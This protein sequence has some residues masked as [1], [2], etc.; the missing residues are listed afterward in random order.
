MKKSPIFELDYYL[1]ADSMVSISS[2]R[3]LA[4]LRQAAL[5]TVER[6]GRA[7]SCLNA[8]HIR[9]RQRR[10]RAARPES[11]PGAVGAA[12]PATPLL[13]ALSDGRV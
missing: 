8:F 12:C 7:R 6:H 1:L 11:L 4:L 2:M 9:R 5:D 10:E 13:V 3:A